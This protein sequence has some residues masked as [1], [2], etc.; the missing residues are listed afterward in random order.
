VT[1]NEIRDAVSIMKQR[2]LNV[3]ALAMTAERHVGLVE[4]IIDAEAIL[5]GFKSLRQRTEIE[6][7]IMQELVR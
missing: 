3:P 5:R 1:D 4:L 2:V 7:A 6:A